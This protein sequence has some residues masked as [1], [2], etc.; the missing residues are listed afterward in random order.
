MKPAC[1]RITGPTIFEFDSFLDPVCAIIDD[2]VGHDGNRA[3]FDHLNHLITKSPNTRVFIE[4]CNSNECDTAIPIP[5]WAIQEVERLKKHPEAMW[6]EKTSAFS[7]MINK[8]RHSREFLMRLLD[9]LDI[10]TTTYSLVSSEFNNHKPKYWEHSDSITLKD[11]INNHSYSNIAIYNQY[12]RDHIFFTSY[13]HL[14]TEPGWLEESTFITEKSIFPFDAG[15]IPIW[16]GGWKQPSYFR[17]M[18][19]DV[20]DDIVDHSYEDLNSPKE[21]I[22]QAVVRN[23]NLLKNKHL[24]AEF[25]NKNRDRFEANRKLLRSDYLLDFYVNKI[26]DLQLDDYYKKNLLELLYA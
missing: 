22:V 7:F 2:H 25:F 10:S 17:K 4:Y 15:N 19:F 11:S 18:G 8:L 9:E 3:G 23:K 6:T 16:C 14:I 24:A 1:L 20:F 12:T 21:R 26:N 13:V 5:W